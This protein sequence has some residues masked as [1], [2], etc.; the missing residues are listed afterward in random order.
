MNNIH[1]AIAGMGLVTPLG[2]GVENN[3]TALLKGKTG[4]GRLTLF[5]TPNDVSFPVGEV[6]LDLFPE[7]PPQ[8]PPN[9]PDGGEGIPQKC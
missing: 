3:W 5:P 8:N 4:S 1:V 2:R 6:A 7:G 9:G